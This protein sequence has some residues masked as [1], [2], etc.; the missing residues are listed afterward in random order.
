MKNIDKTKLTILLFLLI[1]GMSLTFPFV[2]VQE[3][4]PHVIVSEISSTPEVFAGD[5]FTEI[6]TLTNVGDKGAVRVQLI[7]DIDDPFALIDTS[8]NIFVGS[9]SVDYSKSVMLHILYIR[10]AYYGCG[11]FFITLVTVTNL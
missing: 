6:I 5:T 2:T 7:V 9:I 10:R 8:S 11:V 4:R 1:I 3:N